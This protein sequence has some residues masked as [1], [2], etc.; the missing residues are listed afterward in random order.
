[1]SQSFPGGTWLPSR[2]CG[3]SLT[4]RDMSTKSSLYS[5]PVLG[6][7]H[8]IRPFGILGVSMQKSGTLTF[9][10]SSASESDSPGVDGSLKSESYWN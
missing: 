10:V 1:M 4:M 6:Q 9:G 2:N 5:H 8:V 3:R 7:L